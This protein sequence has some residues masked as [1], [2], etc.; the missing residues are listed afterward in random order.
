MKNRYLTILPAFFIASAML[1]MLLILAS[2]SNT[3]PEPPQQR[4]VFP[5]LSLNGKL[6][7]AEEAAG[8]FL[9]ACSNCVNEFAFVYAFAEIG[10][11]RTDALR[12]LGKT[13]GFA[14][15]SDFSLTRRTTEKMGEKLS[16]QAQEI[17]RKF[18]SDMDRIRR[19]AAEQGDASN[20][21]AIMEVEMSLI[22]NALLEH[23]DEMQRAPDMLEY[24]KNSLM[25]EDGMRRFILD[26]C[27]F[28]AN[29]QANLLAWLYLY[30]VDS[31]P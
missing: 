20:F 19:Q 25:T 11:F 22:I 17:K 12:L 27:C 1:A 4:Y 3:A 18:Q 5:G 21:S 16:E 15:R 31:Q 9:S 14:P 6:Y 30:L 7:S 23:S 13:D 28:M 24:L 2:H 29:E 26:D 8:L 10:K